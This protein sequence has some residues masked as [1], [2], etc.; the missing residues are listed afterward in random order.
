MIRRLLIALTAR[1]PAREISDGSGPYLE[2][3][4]VGTVFGMRVY[5]HRFVA[6][7]PDRGLHDHP[8]RW[9]FSLILAGWYIEQRR[10]GN[11]VR[12]W[13]N[14]L[15]G[16]TFHRVVKPEGA[17]DIW[18]LFVHGG[19]IKTWGFLRAIDGGAVF[20][21]YSYARDA[22]E[23]QRWWEFAPTGQEM[24]ADKEPLQ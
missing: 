16:D 10:D 21:P 7:D 6:S 12:R 22:G 18:T 4:Y 15:S 13:L 3:Y 2:R 17:R 5:L 23:D 19:R 1:L 14:L 9:A 11:H 24:R 20:E 8:W